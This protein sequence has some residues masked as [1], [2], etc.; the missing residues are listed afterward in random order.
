[1]IDM[2]RKVTQLLYAER[3]EVEYF[4]S[5]PSEVD[6][7]LLIAEHA[8]MKAMYQATVEWLKSYFDFEHGRTDT[9]P[10]PRAEFMEKLTNYVSTAH[11]AEK[12]AYSEHKR[13]EVGR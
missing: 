3:L 5:L 10:L 13:N 9:R 4:S 2:Y 8:E 1:M 6:A 11:N 12:K 7:S